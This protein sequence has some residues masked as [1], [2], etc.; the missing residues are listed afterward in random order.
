MM[1]IQFIAG[2]LIFGQVNAYYS[3]APIDACSNDFSLSAAHGAE[4]QSS[5]SPFLT[6]LNQVGY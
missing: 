4:P 1:W 6:L 3:G 2:V 5:P